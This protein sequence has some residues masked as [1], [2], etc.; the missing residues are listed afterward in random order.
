MMVSQAL[1][2]FGNATLC[3]L[4]DT[5]GLWRL[6]L[7]SADRLLLGPFRREPIRIRPVVQQMV[8]AGYSSLPLVALVSV[9][10]G[11]IMALQSAYQL[12]KLG[13]LSLL[14]GLVSVAIVRELAPL[15]TAIIVAGRFGS[16]ISAELGTMKVS[17]EIDAL[18][19]MGIDP[20]SYLVVPRLAALM[21][22]L[23]CLV[24]FGDLVGVLGGM[25][26]SVLGLGLSTTAYLMDSLDALQIEDISTG[27]VKAAAFAAVMG[28]IGCH[29]GLKTRGGAEGVG[30]ATTASVVRSL[31]LIIGAD[32]FVTAYFYVRN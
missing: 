22:S 8:R 6:G 29:Q 4:A 10:M 19:V 1:R 30:R 14:A 26:V 21:L 18:I 5:G 9:L 11:M 17:Q 16:S 23:P 24:V 25:G 13:G 20:T 27:L 32:L 28:L 31:V 15:M 2:Y 12:R 3:T 7:R